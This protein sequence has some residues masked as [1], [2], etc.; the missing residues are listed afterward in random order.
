[1][2]HDRDLQEEFDNIINDLNVP[3]TADKFTPDVF[4]DT[5]DFDFR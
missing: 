4:D 2:K 3:E 5:V 1:L